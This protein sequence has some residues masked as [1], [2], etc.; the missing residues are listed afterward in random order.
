V[1]V[2]H[3]DTISAL[4]AETG[5]V[6]EK[7]TLPGDGHGFWID[8]K[9]GKIFVSLTKPGQVGIVDLAKHEMAD[10]FPLALA[11]GNSPIVYDAASGRVFVGCRKEPMVIVLDAKTGKELSGVS[12]PGDIDDLLFDAKS[13]R[14]FAICGAGAVAVIE[15]SGD[16]YEVTAKVETAKGARTATLSPTGDR[17]YVGVPA[18]AGRGDAEVRVFAVKPAAPPKP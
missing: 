15:K 8:E 5:K 12:I 1:Y 7:I 2:C 3:G 4:S 14:V 10:K 11:A 9:A 18:Q 13:G 6:K 17:L 16:K